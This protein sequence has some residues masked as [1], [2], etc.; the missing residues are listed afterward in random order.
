LESNFLLNEFFLN[1]KKKAYQW[2]RST[3]KKIPNIALALICQKS[4]ETIL[5]LIHQN[6]GDQYKNNAHHQRTT[7]TGSGP[8]LQEI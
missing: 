7:S 5:L 3:E 4:G 2:E 1:R 6:Q 8:R